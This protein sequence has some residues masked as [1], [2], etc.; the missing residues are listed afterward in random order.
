MI[1]VD[2]KNLSPIIGLFNSEPLSSKLLIKKEG[3]EYSVSL[4]K[5]GLLDRFLPY[6]YI[7]G[8]ED[9]Q[10]LENLRL[11]IGA[12]R[13]DRIFQREE[14]K[15]YQEAFRQN[16]LVLDRNIVEII[17]LQLGDIRVEDLQTAA[18]TPLGDLDPTRIDQL[19]FSLIPFQQVNDLFFGKI[20]EN[21][22]FDSVRSS[23]RGVQGLRERVKIQLDAVNYYPSTVEEEKKWVHEVEVLTSRLGDREMTP[24]Q[25]VRCRNGY[26]HCTAVFKGKGGY[27]TILQDFKKQKTLLICRGTASRRSATG[28]L[29][30]GLNNLI[31]EPGMLAVQALWPQIRTYLSA[32]SI[33]HI[34]LYGKSQGGAQVQY[35]SSLIQAHTTTQVTALTTY[36][37]IG[38]HSQAEEI[39][40]NTFKNTDINVSAIVNE[41]DLAQDEIDCIPLVGGAHVGLRIPSSSLYSLFPEGSQV[42]DIK[43][44]SLFQ[45]IRRF[46]KSFSNAHIRQTTLKPFQV[47]KMNDAQHYFSIGYELETLRKIT[48]WAIHILTWGLLNPISYQQYFENCSK[49]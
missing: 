19:Y 40:Y 8:A 20:P 32:H 42:S 34:D 9:Q 10:S 33:S 11:L 30:S 12:E 28:G 38:V 7:A 36:A 21:S 16:Q 35:L 14:L 13:I 27:A 2:P 5:L 22:Y 1:K 3:N 47:K 24:G 25:L 37:S 4:K 31:F 46:F 48:A 45:K 41:G 26:F 29:W 49:K 39:F 6:K 43:T 44:L 15:K 23:G 18:A 17:F